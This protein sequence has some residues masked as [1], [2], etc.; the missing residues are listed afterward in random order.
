[1]DRDEF[2]TRLDAAARWARDYARALVL[3]SLPDAMTFRLFLNQSNDD[4]E[5]LRAA[6]MV[7]PEDS[8]RERTCGGPTAIDELWRDGRVPEW[9]D[10]CVSA[11]ER[12]STVIE[13]LCCGRFTDDDTLL[14]HRAEGWPPFHV[15]SPVLPPGY[16]GERFTLRWMDHR[17]CYRLGRMLRG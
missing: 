11:V 16:H 4:I 6:E 1:V 5:P 3:E 8:G 14:Y 2:A 12:G 10:L 13:A 7:F 17:R 15:T 9:V